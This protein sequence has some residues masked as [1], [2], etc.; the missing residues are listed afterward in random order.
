MSLLE[1]FVAPAA[2]HRRMHL[3]SA[4]SFADAA[5]AADY[6]QHDFGLKLT[7]VISLLVCHDDRPLWTL[8]YSL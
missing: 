8:D 4:T 7:A 2:D 1:K 6:L 3:M 5:L